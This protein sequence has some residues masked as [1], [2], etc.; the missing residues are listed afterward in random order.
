MPT[1]W[2]R[3]RD[4]SMPATSPTKT[5]TSPTCLSH[6]SW[7]GYCT[8]RALATVD[9]SKANL[10]LSYCGVASVNNDLL[11]VSR[12]TWTVYCACR[13]ALEMAAEVVMLAT[14]AAIGYG[15]PQTLTD[16]GLKLAE[17]TRGDAPTL[18][19]TFMVW[20]CSGERGSH[21]SQLSMFVF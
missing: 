18:E 17:G 8:A 9:D 15:S 4:S 10:V 19:P 7:Q 16:S 21:R 6:T 5:F 11:M 13:Y 14:G 12:L 20:Q 1:C 2:P 3:W